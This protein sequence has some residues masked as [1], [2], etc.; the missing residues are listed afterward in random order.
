MTQSEANNIDIHLQSGPNSNHAQFKLVCWTDVGRF[1]C[2]VAG[3]K[4]SE[5]SRHS[6]SPQP[7]DHVEGNASERDSHASAGPFKCFMC[8]YLCL[9]EPISSP[10]LEPRGER[11]KQVRGDSPFFRTIVFERKTTAVSL[12]VCRF[13]GMK[14]AWKAS[15]KQVGKIPTG[16]ID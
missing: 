2:G 12:R 16:Y 4:H 14:D 7:K 13:A 5:P 3:G 9:E 6:A 1:S 10:S 11:I 8:L 15:G